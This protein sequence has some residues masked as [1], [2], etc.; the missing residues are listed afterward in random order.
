M[1]SFL[2]QLYLSSRRQAM[3]LG[4]L[5][6]MSVKQMS[7]TNEGCIYV[8]MVNFCREQHLC[9]RARSLVLSLTPACTALARTCTHKSAHKHAQARVHISTH[10]HIHTHLQGLTA[11][12]WPGALWGAPAECLLPGCKSKISRNRRNCTHCYRVVELPSRAGR[13]AM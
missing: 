11:L 8:P 10:A 4:F 5:P 1:S 2:N 6:R 9:A 13:A 3:K 12:R 7:E